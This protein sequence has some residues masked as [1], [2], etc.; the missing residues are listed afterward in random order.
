V[1]FS[2]DTGVTYLKV[3]FSQSHVKIEEKDKNVSQKAFDIAKNRNV[4]LPITKHNCQT[5]LTL[6]TINYSFLSK[7]KFKRLWM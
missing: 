2:I 1:E 5:S 7:Q 6:T 3:L 4:F